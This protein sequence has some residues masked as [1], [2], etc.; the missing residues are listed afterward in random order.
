MQSSPHYQQQQQQPQHYAQHQVQHQVQFVMGANPSASWSGRGRHVRSASTGCMSGL[1]G[2]AQG[3]DEHF[4]LLTP[5]SMHQAEAA[6]GAATGAAAAP[7]LHQPQQQLQQQPPQLQQP[8][9]SMLALQQ[10]ASLQVQQHVSVLSE[11]TAVAGFS[12]QA[13]AS[14]EFGQAAGM[15]AAARGAGQQRVEGLSWQRGHRRSHSHAAAFMGQGGLMGQYD[16][17]AS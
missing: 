4:A 8:L 2:C 16:F 7:Y 15:A 11:T 10:H 17:D 5:T 13:M 6:A 12:T 3:Y 9:G 1:A 14:A